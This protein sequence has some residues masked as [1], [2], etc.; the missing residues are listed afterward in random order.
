MPSPKLVDALAR[1]RAEA[2]ACWDGWGEREA[3]LYAMGFADWTIEG[4]MIQEQEY[5]QFLASKAIVARVSGMDVKPETIN[6]SLYDFQRDFTVWALR[7]GRCAIFADTGLGKTRMQLEWATFAAGCSLIVAPLSVA[8]QTIREGAA[9]GTAVHYTRSGRDVSSGINITNYEMIEA[10][11]PTKFGAVVLDESSILKG[12]DGKTRA[13]LT[14]M[15]ASTPYRLC[16]TAT[17]APNDITEIANHAEFLGIMSRVDMLAAFFLH[18]SGT[19]GQGEGW[20]LKRHAGIP[21]YRWLASW[22]MSIRK[23]SELGYSD[24]GYD[25]PPLNIESLWV[26]SSYIPE[27]MLFPGKLHGIHDRTKARRATLEDRVLAIADVVNQSTEQWILWCGLDDEGDA[28]WRQIP[29]AVTIEGSD[30]AEVKRDRLEK[31]QAGEIRVLVTKLKIAGFGLNLQNAHNMAFVGL[32][33]SWEM[34]YQGIRRC[35]RFGQKYPVRVLIVLSEAERDILDNIRRKEKQAEEM[36]GRLIENLKE[37]E[38]MEIHGTGQE[39][40]YER[41]E[42]QGEGWQLLLGDS[43][44]R[45]KEIGESSVGLSIY[46]PPFLSLYSYSPTERDL[47][48]CSTTEQFFEHYDFIIRD[49]LR[50]T[51]PGRNTCVHVSQVPATM[52]HDGY[53]GL[54]DFRGDVIRAYDRAGWIYHGEV[55][56]GKNPQAQAVRTHS[57][58]LLF[59]QLRKDSSWLRP[60]MADYI[61]VFRKPGDNTEPIKP[62]IS[63]EDWIS[64]AYPIWF[65]IKETDTLNAVE[66]KGQNDERH[67]CPLQLGTIERCVRLWSNPGDLVLSPFAGIG[68]EG[69][70][71]IR[72][73]RKFIGIELKDSYWATAVKNLKRAEQM[74]G[75]LF[76][77]PLAEARGAPQEPEPD[78]QDQGPDPDGDARVM[79]TSIDDLRFSEI[80]GEALAE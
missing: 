8:A 22:S 51:K 15:F 68:S 11:D 18:D 29:G 79:G 67:I 24:E 27:G 20:R 70:V 46:S 36:R 49:L 31:F 39:W 48:N 71:S 69:Y 41:N 1:C 23:P 2:Q 66:G 50:V 34:Y 35:W 40:D 33:D 19:K 26:E 62:D 10:F 72:Q 65:D 42:A 77:E 60:A 58:A 28:L 52:V 45:L 53:I 17:P 38:R 43:V 61:L 3:W 57:K 56:I 13:K 30:S 14:R 44:E 78:E 55:C 76:T 59:V 37:F 16:C 21:F 25:L 74:Q 64:W 75:G 4:R 9:I 54:K 47:G 32:S 7:K 63:N 5:G 73:G 6:P 80:V 12:L